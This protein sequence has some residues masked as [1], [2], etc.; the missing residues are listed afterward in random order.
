M[1]LSVAQ[2]VSLFPLD[3]FQE[4]I[5]FAYSAAAKNVLYSF[6]FLLLLLFARLTQ[7]QKRADGHMQARYFIAT[8]CLVSLSKVARPMMQSLRLRSRNIPA[9]MKICHISRLAA[10]QQQHL[11]AY[12]HA[13][14]RAQKCKNFGR[15]PPPMEHTALYIETRLLA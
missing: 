7:T 12:M 9:I 14:V 10:T 13:Q 3:E 5:I 11:W 8:L 2:M 1:A 6:L 4:D 15:T